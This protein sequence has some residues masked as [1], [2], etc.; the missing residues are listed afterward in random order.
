M[1]NISKGQK[2]I[3]FTRDS[4]INIQL[5]QSGQL[6][7]WRGPTGAMT[8][9]LESDLI[10]HHKDVEAYLRWEDDQNSPQIPLE[11][12]LHDTI[13]GTNTL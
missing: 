11:D 12:V 5:S 9:E 1:A 13:T 2:L 6:V 4:G 8:G 10:A 3:R 7:K